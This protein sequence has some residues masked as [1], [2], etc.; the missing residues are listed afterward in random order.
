M[1][2]WIVGEIC[3]AASGRNHVTLCTPDWLS[4]GLRIFQEART[5]SGSLLDPSRVYS[6]SARTKEPQRR[7][8]RREESEKEGARPIQL[9]LKDSQVTEDGPPPRAS[10]LCGLSWPTSTAWIWLRLCAWAGGG[11]RLQQ[12]GALSKNAI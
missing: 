3:P 6:I 4:E 7:D 12:G 2:R 5:R 11:G 1:V 10:R 8:G 9:S